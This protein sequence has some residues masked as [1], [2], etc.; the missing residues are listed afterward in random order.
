MSER[1]LGLHLSHLVEIHFPHNPVGNYTDVYNT[2]ENDGTETQRLP[3][4]KDGD[5][6]DIEPIV[7]DELYGLQFT[8]LL[9][10]GATW[11]VNYTV[12]LEKD[13][14]YPIPRASFNQ[15]CSL[16]AYYNFLQ[17]GCSC[18]QNY[19]VAK[20]STLKFAMRIT[21]WP[22]EPFAQNTTKKFLMIIVNTTGPFN[23]PY[24]LDAVNRVDELFDYSI[25]DLGTVNLNMSKGDVIVPLTLFTNAETDGEILSGMRSVVSFDNLGI[26]GNGDVS[27]PLRFYL[28]SLQIIYF[29][30]LIYVFY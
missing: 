7:T 22:W 29:M 12:N 30:I 2:V 28:M 26:D 11:V 3:F 17:K 13:I 9:A 4:D 5:D 14:N 6:F 27:I 1:I 15:N 21:D 24:Y 8:K 25:C 20:N 19:F 23:V 18:D 10:N 16:S